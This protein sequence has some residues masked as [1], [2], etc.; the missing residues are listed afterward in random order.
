M[1]Y[2]IDNFLDKKLL[3]FITTDLV[4]F[5][6]IDTGDKSFW[7][8]ETPE[9][10]LQYVIKKLEFIEQRTI[11]SIISFFREAKKG[12]DNDWRIHNDSIINDQKPERAIVLYL[13]SN[14]DNK[15]NGTA[16]WE[17]KTYGDTYKESNTEEFNR[18]LKEDAND[19]DK[20]KLKSIV[21]HKKNRLLSYPSNYFHS[22]YPNEF[23]KSRVVFVMF[24]YYEN[25]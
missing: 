25:L 3:D 7:I 11:K 6:E 13:S 20:W 12:Q 14:N 21:G 15:L 4:D 9:P 19:I 10:F 2:F 5:K 18:M 24:Y 23:I 1:I 8:K 22:K 16:F 17:H